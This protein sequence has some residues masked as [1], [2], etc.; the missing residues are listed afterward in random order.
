M[1]PRLF[2]LLIFVITLSNC[3]KE[4]VQAPQKSFFEVLN[5]HPD[6]AVEI[7]V[8]TALTDLLEERSSTYQKAQLDIQL[9]DGT[10]HSLHAQLKTRGQTRSKIC[11]FPPLKLKIAEESLIQNNWDTQLSSYKLVTDCIGNKD[12]VAKEMLAYQIFQLLSDISFKV[13]PLII[14]YVNKN[15]S[16]KQIQQFGFIIESKKA[17]AKRLDAVPVLDHKNMIDASQYQKMTVFQ[18][19]IG[20]T[21]W[22]LGRYHNIKYV[23]LTGKKM[24]SPV[25]YDFDYAG[26]VDA[27]YALPP[28]QLPI[29]AVKERFFQYRGK[30]SEQLIHTLKEIHAQEKNILNTCHDHPLLSISAKEE[31]TQYLTSFFKLVDYALEHQDEV[32]QILKHTNNKLSAA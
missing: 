31:V 13:Q 27:P 7:T 14:T 18:Y 9:S 8:T 10:V 6:S 5:A 1:T 23:Q 25:P 17:L 19:M 22:N 16:E 12:L 24:P 26:L 2:F 21:D 30:A 11:D 4:V 20:N 32:V 28:P 3:T 15:D 29:K